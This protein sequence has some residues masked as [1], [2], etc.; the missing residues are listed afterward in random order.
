M[1]IFCGLVVE[2]QVCVNEEDYLLI[3]LP[4]YQLITRRRQQLRSALSFW[5]PHRLTCLGLPTAR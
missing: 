4:T 2:N 5:A 1:D 3:I